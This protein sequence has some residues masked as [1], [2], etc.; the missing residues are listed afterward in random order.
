MKKLGAILLAC[1]LSVSLVGCGNKDT[2]TTGT[3]DN[4]DITKVSGKVSLDGSTS[5]KKMIDYLVEAIAQENPNLQLEPQYTGSG[6]GIQSLMDGKTDI[7]DSSRALNDEEKA[8]GLVENVVAL[9]GI[10]VI[11]DKANTVTN[12]TKQQLADIYTGKIKNWKEVG[13]ADQGIVV[14]GREDGSG[15]RDGFESILDIKGKCVLASTLNE[16]GAVIAKVEQTPGAIGYASLDLAQES[17]NSSIVSIENV[18]PSEATILDGTYTLQR[19]FV[20]ATKGEVK[21]Q[22]PEVKAVF[23][24]VESAKGKEIIKSAGLVIPNK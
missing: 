8:A 13:G 23:D 9:D 15:T 2:G 18:Q 22:K 19:P 24:F 12:L 16:T 14:I 6:T 21:D 10:A 17:K 7:G 20:M 11:V 3:T 4:S 1:V 5:M